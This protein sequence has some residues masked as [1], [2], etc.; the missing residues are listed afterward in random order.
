MGTSCDFCNVLSVLFYKQKS[1]V[2]KEVSEMLLD[3]IHLW[4]FLTECGSVMIRTPAL[5]SRDPSSDFYVS[6]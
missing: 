1:C 2:V 5:Y 3:H 4:Q 6:T